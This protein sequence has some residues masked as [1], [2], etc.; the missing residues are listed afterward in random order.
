MIQLYA[1]DASFYIKKVLTRD[2]R[3]I[4]A[5]IGDIIGSVY[6]GN[7]I[8]TTEFPLFGRGCRFTDDTVLTAA[9]ADS[10]ISGIS[11]EDKLLEYYRYYP[12]AGYGRNFQIWGSSGSRKPY[13]SWGNGSA[14]RVSPTG[15]AFP[16]LDMV[17]TEAKKSAAV[18]HNHPEGVK[19]AQ[20]VA[21][22]V[23]MAQTGSS[24]NDIREYI[25]IRFYYDLGRTVEEIRPAY[26]FDVSCQGSVPE[27]IIC[28]LESDSFEDAV[29]LAV[30]LG[31]DSDTQACIAGAIAHAFYREIPITIINEAEQ[32]L[33]DRLLSVITAF[34][35]SFL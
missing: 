26:G 28:F 25:E 6:E 4:G 18:T 21:A 27:S 7:P 22:A 16:T 8:K 11:Y 12:R 33:D 17:M 31:G 29:R 35:D 5:V 34:S 3:M 19:G 10:I 32:Y 15:Y 14:M 30:S 13:N 23:F 9:V 2:I 24:K 20:A 1:F